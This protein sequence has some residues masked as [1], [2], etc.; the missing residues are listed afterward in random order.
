MWEK[1]PRTRKHG[2]LFIPLAYIG[3]CFQ[4]AMYLGRT[5]G[6]PKAMENQNLPQLIRKSSEQVGNWIELSKVW[7]SFILPQIG[8]FAFKYKPG[9]NPLFKA[10]HVGVFGLLGSSLIVYIITLV[11]LSLTKTPTPTTSRLPLLIWH[12]CWSCGALTCGI[13]SSLLFLYGWVIFC[14]YAL[15]LWV[16]PCKPLRNLRWLR[17][18]PNTQQHLDSVDLIVEEVQCFIQQHRLLICRSLPVLLPAPPLLT[19]ILKTYKFGSMFDAYFKHAC[20]GLL[21]VYL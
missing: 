15:F 1:N 21:F 17:P 9:E 16:A 11:V 10:D 6:K 13:L 8:L 19:K 3:T 18:P 12:V 7:T 20:M 2:G 4:C 14:F 5:L